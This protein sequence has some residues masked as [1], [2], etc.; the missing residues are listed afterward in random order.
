IILGTLPA[1]TTS[2]DDSGLAAGTE[3]DYHIQAFNV[4]G[5]SDFAG[6]KVRTVSDA[7]TGLAA[8]PGDGRVTLTWTAPTGAETYNVYRSLSPDDL[9]ALP[10][11]SGV[12]D[13]TFTDTTAVNGT[14]YYYH[15]TAVNTG[16]ESEPSAPASATPAPSPVAQVDGVTVSG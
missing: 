5:F 12:A 15:V 1:D 8:A 16:G 7:P 14:T 3:Y 9:G 4:A 13:T 2:Y 10:V 11:Q 6:V